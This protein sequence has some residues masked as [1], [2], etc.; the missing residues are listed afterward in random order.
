[1]NLGEL[2]WYTGCVFTRD[3]Q[4]GKI[5]VAQTAY[6]NQI[7]ERFSVITTSSTPAAP[8]PKL[9]PLQCHEEECEEKFRALIRVLLWVANMTQPD[10]ANSVRTLTRHMQAPSKTHWKAGLRVLK[11]L[12]KT[13]DWGVT[14][15]KTG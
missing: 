12:R 2:K 10:I 7:C 13:R 3:R 8:S 9:L 11:F 4:A 5:K 6:I 14:F 1:E 15:Q